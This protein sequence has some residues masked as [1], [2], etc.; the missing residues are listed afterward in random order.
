MQGA[1]T[2]NNQGALTWVQPNMG[3]AQGSSINNLPG[4]LLDCAADA[5][6]GG[7]AFSGQ[8]TLNN[9]GTLRKSA[10]LRT[11]IALPALNTGRIEC[12]AGRL[13]F[14]D[15]RQTAGRTL[16]VGGE[17]D[18]DFQAQPLRIEGGS[19][20]GTGNIRG[21]VLN[22]GGTISPG[23]AEADSVGIITLAESFYGNSLTQGPD[24]TM[25]IQIGGAAPGS[26]DQVI[27]RDESFLTNVALDGTLRV[28]LINGYAP[29]TASFDILILDGPGAL[30]GVFATVQAPPGFS[31]AY[32]S[33]RVRLDYIGHI[34]SADFNQD[35][36][37]N[38]DDLSEFITCF[39]LDLQFPSFCPASDFN[40][41]SLLNPD[42]LS[43]FIT[44][45]FLSLQ[46]GC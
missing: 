20:E 37:L 5:T 27:V 1:F 13:A 32:L 22:A 44:I 25:E 14:A 40:Q 2:L 42:D 12:V 36:T 24:G 35:G 43:E 30:T 4:A 21:P 41:D 7:F 45:F 31:V 19:L 23:M 26:Y 18:A 11:I 16:L 9:A 28:T 38:P 3:I 39:F 29:S 17:L 10:G 46:F 34:C 15:F 8:G 6:L 33:D